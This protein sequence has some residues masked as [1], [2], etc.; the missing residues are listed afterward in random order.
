[1]ASSVIGGERKAAVG[2]HSCVDMAVP[3]L[4]SER[5]E[6]VLE[7]GLSYT[8]GEPVLVR[9]R[10]R[11]RRYGLRDDGRAVALA[12]RPAG[13]RDCAAA[14]VEAHDLNVNRSGV[15]FVPAVEGGVDRDWL[16]RR[17]AETSLALYN[18][19]LELQ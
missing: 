2:W 8:E 5:D 7:T 4:R 14:V 17:V 11:G 12:G 9:V 10:K 13:W 18:A 15:V 1:M 6:V 3:E 16:G 19:L